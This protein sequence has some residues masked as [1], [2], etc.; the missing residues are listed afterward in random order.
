MK[1]IKCVL[2]KAG[3]GLKF[4]I[5]ITNREKLK[6][7]H[8]SIKKYLQKNLRILSHNSSVAFQSR[9]TVSVD[10]PPITTMHHI[11]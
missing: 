6:L 9:T 11:Q 4:C 1:S 3:R 5:Y 10:R 8:K 2:S 7:Y